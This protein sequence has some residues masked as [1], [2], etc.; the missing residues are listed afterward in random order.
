[1]QKKI[2]RLFLLVAL[3]ATPTAHAQLNQVFQN[4][5]NRILITDF[6]TSGTGVHQDHYKPRAF[7]AN[8][9]L[10][11]AL[12]S[13]I[14]RNVSSFPLP[15]TAAGVAFD[16]T[17]GQVLNIAESLGPIFAETAQ[18]LGAGKL[19]LGVNYTYLSLNK[20]RGLSTRDIRFTFI[21]QDVGPPG[22][23]DSENESDIVDVFLDLD[24][25][26]SL[27][28][29]FGTY[30]VSKNLD[31]G[32][33]IP[34]VNL[35]L[36]GNA[37]AVINSFTFANLGEANHRFNNDR[38][39]PDL[40]DLVP[41]DAS[42]SGLGDVGLRAKYSFRRGAKLDMAALL[43]V[44]LPTGKK[45]DF[46]GTGQTN[47]KVNWVMSKKTG[48]FSPHLNLGYERRGADRDSDQLELAAGF[49]QKILKGVNFAF[50]LFGEFDLNDKE[51]PSF[52]PQETETI[53]E[54]N[55]MTQ[56]R[57]ERRIDLSNIDER[58]N[59]NILN[60]SIGFRAAPSDRFLVLGNILVPLN[61]GG[62]RSSVAP[63]LGMTISF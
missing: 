38:L 35:S 32:V 8:Q 2:M 14:A 56:A 59:D 7:E 51:V 63:T 31:I 57:Y 11:P 29:V 13:L 39:R 25:N 1:M 34:F 24:V 28:A 62:L 47:L 55:K 21:H 17:T 52:F 3:M 50:E 37:L 19:N 41:Y 15:A 45:E 60:A 48:D 6:Q 26:A 33:A 42:A 9:N 58:S 27:F 40:D 44:R 43:D 46:L 4:I 61:D 10:T 23:G 22:L 30:G 12:N 36:S 18:T 53:F 16:F 5:F 20:L 54:Q 49:A